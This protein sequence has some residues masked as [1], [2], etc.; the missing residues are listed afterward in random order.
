MKN[1]LINNLASIRE[2]WQKIKSHRGK[3]LFWASVI[4]LGAFLAFGVYELAGI[5]N[6]REPI[7]IE[8]GEVLRPVHSEP[9]GLPAEGYVVSKNGSKYHLPWCPG[10]STIKPE[11]R[12]V[13][14]TRQAVELAGYEPAAN[15]PGL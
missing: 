3:E 10:A 9:A 12:I 4:V 13:Y 15:C 2:R 11:N 14:Q 6:D 1:R 8:M 5:Y 7:T